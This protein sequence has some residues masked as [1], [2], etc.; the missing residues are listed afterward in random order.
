MGGIVTVTI[1]TLNSKFVPACRQVVESLRDI[2]RFCVPVLPNEI[3][4][5]ASTAPNTGA[6]ANTTVYPVIDSQT[7]VVT[8]V[9]DEV[10]SINGFLLCSSCHQLVQFVK[11]Y[12]H[13]LVA[14]VG[15]IFHIGIYNIP[16][17]EAHAETI[18]A[19][20]TNAK[21]VERTV[22][23]NV[24]LLGLTSFVSFFIQDRL[25]PTC[26]NDIEY[27]LLTFYRNE[28]PRIVN[29]TVNKSVIAHE[30]GSAFC[31]VGTVGLNT[32]ALW[33]VVTFRIGGDKCHCIRNI[34][35]SKMCTPCLSSTQEALFLYIIN[36][37]VHVLLWSRNT[38]IL[39]GMTLGSILLTGDAE[40]IQHRIHL[41]RSSTGV[42]VSLGIGNSCGAVT[43]IFLLAEFDGLEHNRY[44]P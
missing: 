43:L 5:V 33:Q 44:I 32:E 35:C 20:I 28:L 19:A 13:P 22:L 14:L 25:I 34:F 4:I 11:G 23:A 21:I 2:C 26:T 9:N 30:V 10:C 17:I 27:V 37:I 31:T 6:A 16:R 15:R 12:Q 18:L 42:N 38:Y 29:R 36:I 40:S 24:C 39:L 8:R 1:V 41:S 3:Y 7:L